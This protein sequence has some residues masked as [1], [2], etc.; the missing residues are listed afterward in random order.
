M[1]PTLDI[2]NR[3]IG[4]VAAGESVNERLQTEW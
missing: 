4:I 3:F 2:I 1:E